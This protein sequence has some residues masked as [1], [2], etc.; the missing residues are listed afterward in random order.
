MLAAASSIFAA[1]PAPDEVHVRR[2]TI[3]DLDAIVALENAAFRSDRVSRRQWQRHLESLSAE[4]LVAIRERH[5]VGV[6]MLL[7][8][9]GHHIVRLYSLAVAAGQRGRG[10]GERLLHAAELAAAR[11]EG[12]AL[13]LEVRTDNVAAQRLYERNGYLGIGGKRGFYEDGADALRYEKTLGS[14]RPALAWSSGG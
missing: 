10:I 3:N 6:A 4:V 11:R 8:H 9:R 13:R 1:D 5:L 7:F 14:A 12:R 2:A